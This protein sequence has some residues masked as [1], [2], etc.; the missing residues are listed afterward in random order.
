MKY[1]SHRGNLFGPVKE[2]EN[3]PSQ[4]IHCLKKGFDVEID[5]RYNGRFYLGHDGAQHEVSIDFLK[6]PGLWIHCKNVEAAAAL[7]R[8]DLNYFC[9]DKDDYTVTSKGYVWLSPTHKKLFADS[10]CVMPEDTLWDFIKPR[11]IEFTGI[12][13]DNIY[14]YRNYVT[15][16]RR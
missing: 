11:L 13:S 10:I 12:C 8:Y 9:I 3:H 16:L 1:I 14:Y 4:I 6:E 2:W 7:K 15:D 5:V